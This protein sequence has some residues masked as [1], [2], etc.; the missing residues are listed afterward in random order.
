MCLPRD[1]VDFGLNFKERC[2]I[3]MLEEL[4]LRE[5]RKALSLMQ[6]QVTEAMEMNQGVISKMRHN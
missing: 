6:E 4:A 5:L 1:F 2:S 3:A